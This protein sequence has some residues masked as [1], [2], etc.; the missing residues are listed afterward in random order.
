[1]ISLPNDTFPNYL[2]NFH[3]L[4]G[5]HDFHVDFHRQKLTI[6]G[7][8]DPEKVVRAIKKTKKNA[9]ICSNIELASPSKPTEPEPR[10]HAP[11]PDE[12]QPQPAE[13]PPAQASRSSEP[14]PEAAPSTAPTRH[15]AATQQWQNPGTKDIGQ[16]HMIHHHQPNYVNRFSSEAASS[17]ASTW[18][19]ATQQWQNNPGTED[20]RQAHMMLHH[21]HPNYINSS[22]H[23]YVDLRDRYHNSQ[24]FLHEQS[25]SMHVTHSYNTHTPSSYVTEYEYVSSPSWHTH[26][27]HMEHYNGDYQNGNVNITS[28]FS[29]DNPNACSIV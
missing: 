29:D 21:H 6:I 14:P 1:M 9:I 20:I 7:W 26:Y 15:Y 24:V 25:Q 3:I 16:V 27:N 8:A 19:S 22:G 5:I 2:I 13:T 23:N 17:T 18:H 28:M 4:A 10:E 11:G 12:G